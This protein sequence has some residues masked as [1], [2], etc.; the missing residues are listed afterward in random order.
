MKEQIFAKEYNSSI[1]FAFTPTSIQ[2]STSPADGSVVFCKKSKTAAP[3]SARPQMLSLQRSRATR[4]RRQLFGVTRIP[5]GHNPKQVH[6]SIPHTSFSS[7]PLFRPEHGMMS[8]GPS[9]TLLC[10]SGTSSRSA[11]PLNQPTR[12][13]LQTF[14]EKVNAHLRLTR[15]EW[16]TDR[17]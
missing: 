7:L 12:K 9:L 10:R 14:K 6:K 1:F 13:G 2:Y 3:T 11:F 8:F 4:S 16:A 17:L 5:R 15:W